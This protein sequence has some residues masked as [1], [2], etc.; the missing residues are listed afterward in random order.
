M[1]SSAAAVALATPFSRSP[2]P[3]R[4]F[5]HR[6]VVP[7]PSDARSTFVAPGQA[8]TSPFSSV[9]SPPTMPN[10]SLR[11]LNRRWK[12]RSLIR[13]PLISADDQWGMW[14]A[15]FA[16]GAFGLWSEKTKIG[17]MVSAALVSTLIGLTASN[18]GIIPCEAPAYSTVLEFLL[19]LTIPL[20]LFR[21]DL[22]RV[23]RS[24]GKLLLAFLLG[25]VATVVGT[26]VAFLLV[27]M[28]S[29]GQD[30]WKIAA[31]L[32]GSYIGGSVNYVAIS[33]ALS[34]SPS[35]V[36]AG[37]AADNVICAVYFLILF[38]LASKVPPE[39]SKSPS[40][41]SVSLKLDSG[42]KIPI[43][44]TA[45]AV[46]TAFAIC[47]IGTYITKLSGIQGGGLP[48]I[49]ALVVILATILPAQFGSLAHSGDAI[50]LVLMQVM[51]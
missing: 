7:S 46:A 31:A 39:T 24:T 38:A 47:K 18:V 45:T 5:P 50:S 43:L 32:M 4:R 17:S 36:A 35:V 30:S 44:Q 48:I 42:G 26:V 34:I 27:P 29:L 51:D 37:V 23:F 41:V 1:A 21:A 6:L 9:V 12:V 22:R 49:T 8:R 3:P 40:D 14:T 20:L 25:L 19:P 11:S 2:P 10:T 28:R 15:L 33:E 13:Q 16:T